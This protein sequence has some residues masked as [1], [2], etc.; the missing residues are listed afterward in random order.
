MA[1]A[2]LLAAVARGQLV[3]TD[4]DGDGVDDSIDECTDTEPGDMIDADGCSICPCEETADGDA[5]A[6]HDAYVQC[7]AAEAKDRRHEHMVKRK[8]MR[9]MIKHAKASSCGNDELTRCC[10]YAG[11]DDDVGKCKVMSV[12][13]CDALWEESDYV[14]D[15]GPGSCTPNPCGF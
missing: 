6:S 12:D 8:E 15:A 5:W 4:V 10:T 13:K 1:C 11:D 7:V 14:D 9:A 2:V 3:P